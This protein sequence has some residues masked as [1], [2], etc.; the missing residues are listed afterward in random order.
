MSPLAMS[1][2]RASE[3]QSNVQIIED[4]MSKIVKNLLPHQHIKVL[5]RSSG[6]N[7][8]EISY[9]NQ[10]WKRALESRGI[11]AEFQL[12]KLGDYHDFSVNFIL[13]AAD[14]VQLAEV[15]SRMPNSSLVKGRHGWQVKHS[16]NN[17]NILSHIFIT[18]ET[19]SCRVN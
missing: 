12:E 10:E 5:I 3:T 6:L 2:K 17:T 11:E 19:S 18:T 9:L 7:K 4:Y 16:L 13:K 1:E 14:S 15:L 8:D